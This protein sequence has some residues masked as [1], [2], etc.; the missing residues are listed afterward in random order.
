MSRNLVSEFSSLK[1]YSKISEFAN[2]DTV[3]IQVFKDESST[4][5]A[6]TT[7][8]CTQISTTGIYFFS[9]VGLDSQPTGTTLTQYNWIM[10]DTTTKKSSGQLVIG[11]WPESVPQALT[12]SS[13]CRI[14]T[15]LYEADGSCVV[16]PNTFANQ[17]TDENSIE[18][19]TVFNDGTR[20]FKLGKY[21]PSYSE[22]TGEAFWLVPRLSTVDVKLT[23]FGVTKTSALVPD[24]STID[25]KTWLDSL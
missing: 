21:S 10:S 14:T 18:L 19:K 6:I 1:V 13:T 4:P 12:P 8:A 20:Y 17:S 16:D 3:T 24:V 11:G 22:L 15:P 2:G 25:L 9:M 23:S 5:E 7:P